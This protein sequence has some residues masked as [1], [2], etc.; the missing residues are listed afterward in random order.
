M[1][2]LVAWVVPSKIWDLFLQWN[3]LFSC[4]DKR[5]LWNLSLP[6]IL[7]GLWK[8]QNRRIFENST[9]QAKRV[10]LKIS[11]L[12]TENLSILIP[13]ASNGITVGPQPTSLGTL[14]ALKAN[15]RAS[16]HWNLPPKGWLAINFDKASKGNSG[17]VGAR[18][19]IRDSHGKI[20][21]ILTKPL[22]SQSSHFVEEWAVYSSLALL[23]TLQGKKVV[24]TEHSLNIINILQGKAT[25]SWSILRVMEKAKGILGRLEAFSIPHN[26]REANALA[27]S[28]A[29][30][31]ITLKHRVTWTR[32]F[33]KKFLA[34][35]EKD[36][37]AS[38]EGRGG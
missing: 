16:A 28:V 19:V 26:F 18:G 30:E 12:V 27:D 21:L 11:A 25:S 32:D 14:G 8:E 17:P 37:N 7:W 2:D 29:K 13:K 31:A 34:L 10:A 15:P 6:H 24:I 5:T 1:H 22:G 4:Q 36:K 38:S 3:S 20:L 33:P 35:A 23:E 9:F